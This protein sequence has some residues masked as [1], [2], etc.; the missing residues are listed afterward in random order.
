MAETREISAVESQ[1]P[2]SKQHF[3]VLD[4]LRGVAAIAVVL[5]HSYKH[6]GIVPNG[7]L[8][9]DLFFML[10]GFVIAY[11][12]DERL[13]SGMSRSDFV[14]RRIIRL[15]PMVLAGALGGI[16]LALVH[17]L[18]S[19]GSGYPLPDLAA[20]GGLSLLVLPYLGSGIDEKAFSFNPPL[21]SL[22]FELLANFAYV[23]FAKRMTNTVLAVII[24][25]GVVGVGLGGALGGG[26]KGDILLGVPRVASGFFGGVLLFRLWRAGRLPKAAGNFWLLSAALLAIFA[27]PLPIGGWLYAPCFVVF[28]AVIILAANAKASASKKLCQWLGEASYPLYLLHWLTLYIFAFAGTK[29]G[30]VGKRYWI[31]VAVHLVCAPLIAHLAARYYETPTRN[32]LS[33][34][35]K[36]TSR[37]V[38]PVSNAA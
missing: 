6:G 8:A 33:R 23:I 21:W 34:L 26:G 29:V 30:L 25:L 3:A 13:R 14:A 11:S 36:A 10:S 28:L 22:F 38:S 7:P 9:V 32:L 20:S 31:V 19:P 27:I 4:G 12:Y 18:M 35:W 24:V 16:V 15:Y 1:A 37:K 2:G 17:N 5:F